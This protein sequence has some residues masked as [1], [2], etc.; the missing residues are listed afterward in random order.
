MCLT[1]TDPREHTTRGIREAKAAEVGAD[2]SG[3][4]TV[5]A[6]G[7]SPNGGGNH[8]VRLAVVITRGRTTRVGVCNT[9][10]RT[11]TRRRSTNGR[12]RRSPIIPIGIRSARYRNGTRG[13]G[14]KPRHR[15]RSHMKHRISSHNRGNR[16]RSVSNRKREQDK[17]RIRRQYPRHEIG[18]RSRKPGIRRRKHGGS[19][20]GR[21]PA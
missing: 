2:T 9:G 7:G 5:N 6:T 20:A 16:N 11:G 10:C 14:W 1:A 8:G 12:R 17:I 15:I 4:T 13:R 3:R 18:S 19:G 21:N